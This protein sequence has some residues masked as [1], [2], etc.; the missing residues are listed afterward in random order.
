[1]LMTAT[2]SLLG[3]SYGQLMPV[4]ARDFLG[5]DASGMSILYI[6]AG[7]GTCTSAA[8]LVFLR[9]PRRKGLI[10]V[11]GAMSFAVALALFALSRVLWV[12]EVLLFFAGAALIIFSTSATTLLQKLAPRELRG[13]IMSVNTIAWQGLE[14]VGVLLTG[15]LATVWMAPPV[16]VGAAVVMGIAVI[17]IAVLRS[18]VTRVE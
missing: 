15:A 4:F 11:G 10:A 14:Y 3:R 5:L 18:E 7:L 9:D 17:A 1:V 13:R 12:S 16:V 8:V 2:V 6:F